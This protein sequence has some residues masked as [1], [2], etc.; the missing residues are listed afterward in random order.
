[1]SYEGWLVSTAKISGCDWVDP[2]L[3][4]SG[5]LFVG[6]FEVG[7]SYSVEDNRYSGKFHSSHPCEKGTEVGILYNPKNRVESL[8]C[9]ENDSPIGAV[10]ECV[11][12]MLG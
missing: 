5:S 7:F 11:L 1:M 4:S 3:R 12:E 8:V 6:Y 2:P 10:L 9:D